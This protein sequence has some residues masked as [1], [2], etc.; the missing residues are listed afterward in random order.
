MRDGWVSAV[1]SLITSGMTAIWKSG[2]RIAQSSG[3]YNNWSPGEQEMAAI[4]EGFG[5]VLEN[6][7]GV[8]DDWFSYQ[9][10]GIFSENQ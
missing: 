3:G 1:S 10:S 5:K 9:L 2:I 4:T 8:I 7:F 6:F